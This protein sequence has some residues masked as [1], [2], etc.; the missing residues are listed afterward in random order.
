MSEV[1]VGSSKS[2]LLPCPFCGGKA[3][4]L[5]FWDF[6]K[7]SCKNAECTAHAADAPYVQHAEGVWYGSIDEARAAWNTRAV[8]TCRLI[9]HDADQNGVFKDMRVVYHECSNCGKHIDPEWTFCPNCGRK[10][11][12]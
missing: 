6:Y 2:E 5:T 4:T 9:E 10:V 11:E 3:E 7:F 1:R 12:R 8:E